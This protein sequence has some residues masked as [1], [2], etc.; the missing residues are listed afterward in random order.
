[1]PVLYEDAVDPF[2]PSTTITPQEADKNYERGVWG[3]GLESSGMVSIMQLLD[4]SSKPRTPYDPAFDEQFKQLAKRSTAFARFPDA[5]SNVQNVGEFHQKEWDIARRDENNQIIS[6]AGIPGILAA[7]V[8]GLVSPTILLPGGAIANE[9]KLGTDL[10]KS[11]ASVSAWAVVG[12]SGD[13]VFLR[14]AYPTRTNLES[15]TTIGG[16]ALL[17]AVLGGAARLLSKA[18]VTRITAGMAR[19]ESDLT[20]SPAI[21]PDPTGMSTA[22]AKE[23]LPH[24]QPFYV[25]PVEGGLARGILDLPK[26][27]LGHKL[28]A[29]I[30]GKG[31]TNLASEVGPLTRQLKNE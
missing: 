21:H 8:T 9:A 13:E 5:F 24:E 17:G 29:S 3:A 1:M 10:F 16:A 14:A 23:V 28:P 19:P 4:E 31:L 22:G 12:T 25:A 27:I 7:M 15:I 2:V 26:S 30:A 18:D 11:A 20:I 6:A